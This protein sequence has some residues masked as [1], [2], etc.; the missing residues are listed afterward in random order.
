MSNFINKHKALI[1]AAWAKLTTHDP[2]SC[3][4]VNLGEALSLAMHANNNSDALA[5]FLVIQ[6]FHFGWNHGRKS[7]TS[8]ATG[9]STS[10]SWHLAVMSG[11]VRRHAHDGNLGSL[12]HLVPHYPMPQE[13]IDAI[14]AVHMAA[15]KSDMAEV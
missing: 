13:T 4:C 12:K 1:D 5:K 10:A 8:A 9:I 15:R 3:G 14:E 6:G 2:D 7:L 11:A